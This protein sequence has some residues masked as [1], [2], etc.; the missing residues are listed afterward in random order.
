MRDLLSRFARRKATWKRRTKAWFLGHQVGVALDE[1]G[2]APPDQPAPSKFLMQSGKVIGDFPQIGFGK[3]L[4]LFPEFLSSRV[5]RSNG[6]LATLVVRR[7]L[8]MNN[9]ISPPLGLGASPQELGEFF[10]L[11][12]SLESA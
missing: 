6:V 11:R 8:G 3:I 4:L 7:P 12:N 10:V 1:F 9:L 5:L 2:A